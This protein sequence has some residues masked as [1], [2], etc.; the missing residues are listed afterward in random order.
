VRRAP[1]IGLVI[2][3]V[4]LLC[5][6]YSVRPLLEWRASVD[7]LL[8]GVL[9][10]A[11]RVRPGVAA[12]LGFVAGVVADALAP[13][14]FGASALALTIVGFGASWLKEAFFAEHVALNA[15]FLFAGK[16]AFDVAFLLAEGRLG[17]STLLFQIGTWS[18]LSALVTAFVGLAVLMLFRPLI[19]PDTIRR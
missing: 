10:I 2:L 3:F 18:A 19:D 9:L 12:V 1:G 15:V 16:L 13:S 8:I 4:V 7:F 14:A 11:V 5:L 17:G 6:H